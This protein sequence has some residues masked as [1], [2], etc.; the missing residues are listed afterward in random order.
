M[1]NFQHNTK[2]F[3]EELNSEKCEVTNLLNISMKG[4][5]IN[6]PLY[7]YH[8]LKHHKYLVDI[9][10]YAKQLFMIFN[11]EQYNRIKFLIDKKLNVFSFEYDVVDLILYNEFL[12]VQLVKEKNINFLNKFLD[13]YYFYDILLYYSLKY[14]MISLNTFS[15]F[16]FKNLSYRDTIYIQFNNYF[17]LKEDNNTYK[18]L[19]Y[20]SLDLFIRSVINLF[21]NDIN[22]LDYLIKSFNLHSNIHHFDCEYKF[23][24]LFSNNTVKYYSNKIFK[25][26]KIKVIY[27]DKNIENFINTAYTDKGILRIKDDISQYSEFSISYFENNINLN[28]S[29]LTFVSLGNYNDSYIY[30]PY[31]IEKISFKNI[32]LFNIYSI[33]NIANF[34][35]EYDY[36]DSDGIP[37]DEEYYYSFEPKIELYRYINK[38]KNIFLND[39][40]TI[41]KILENPE[42]ILEA[43]KKYISNYDMCIL[44]KLCYIIS[45]CHNNGSPFIILTLIK[46]INFDRFHIDFVNNKLQFTISSYKL[47]TN[48]TEVS[49]FNEDNLYFDALKYTPNQKFNDYLTVINY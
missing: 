36:V 32:D 28:K 33:D 11:I 8:K 35:N 39:I 24:K 1:F 49:S 12:I 17:Y 7:K 23:F 18:I 13:N 44:I 15:L 48:I 14:N 41:N 42:Y 16:D 21:G 4:V 31:D 9:S 40:N 47:S 45:L 20:I 19:K 5:Y 29:E 46:V 43:A 3:Y 34:I 6:E 37:S 26:N 25:P 22:V 38:F 2:L 10:F 30:E 27:K